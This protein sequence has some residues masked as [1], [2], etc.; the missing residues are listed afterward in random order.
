[1]K[2]PTRITFFAFA[3]ALLFGLACAA[4]KEHANEGKGIVQGKAVQSSDGQGIRKV[5]VQLSGGKR[6]SPLEYTTATD[7]AGEFKF[8]GVA[9]GQYH[10]LLTRTSYVWLS[11]IGREELIT[12]EAGRDVTGLLFKMEAAGLITGKIVDADGDAVPGISVRAVRSGKAGSGRDGDQ[13]AEGVTND[14]GEYRIPNL[15]PGRYVVRAD[16][17]SEDKP[18]PNPAEKGH[19][20]ERAVYVSTYYPGTR[21]DKQAGPIQVIPGGIATANF[22]LLSSQAYRVNGTVVGLANAQ[23]SHILLV[24]KNGRP[25]QGT[26]FEEGGRFEFPNVQPGTY[27]VKVLS[28][29]GL[30]E[31][32]RPSMKFE[33]IRTPIVVSTSDVVGLRLQLEAGG[34]VNGKFHLEGDQKINWSKVTAIL[35]PVGEIGIQASM[36]AA[37]ENLNEN[38]FFEIKDVAAGDYQLTVAAQAEEFRDYYLKSVLMDGREVVDTG[39]AV[40]AGT[41]LDVCVSAKGAAIEGTVVDSKAQ[42]VPEVA[43]L[44]I[45]SSGKLGRPDSYQQG[46]TDE[47]GHFLLRGMNP[48]EFTVLALEDLSEDFRSAEFFQKYAS[49]GEKVKLEE[50]EKKSV[51]LTLPAQEGK[52]L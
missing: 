23:M 5:I 12:V 51:V 31:V 24:S 15:H 2:I 7:A 40:S 34:A 38:G 29:T 37:T 39:F 11:K 14:V 42:P 20:R 50:G 1:M 30:A 17:G 48:G 3:C 33:T 47:R 45:P 49:R 28:V 52:S 21:D 19:E 13:E 35:V 44:T 43:V 4:Q 6:E 10:L 22:G 41:T 36:P 46:R 16:P 32:K 27:S 9:P 18:V 25:Q 26:T 8:E